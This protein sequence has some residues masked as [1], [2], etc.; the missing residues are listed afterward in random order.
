LQASAEIM[1]QPGPSHGGL[2]EAVKRTYIILKNQ[3]RYGP[4][5]SAVALIYPSG[6]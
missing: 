2:D 3:A 1:S 4:Y 6:T 5:C